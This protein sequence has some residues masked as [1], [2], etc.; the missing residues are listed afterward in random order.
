MEVSALV[1][2]VPRTNHHICIAMTDPLLVQERNT[3]LAES[4]R[5]VEGL[6][7]DVEDAVSVQDNYQLLMEGNAGPEIV[8]SHT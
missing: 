6:G 4:L 2:A 8:D 1:E 5:S 7:L 3:G